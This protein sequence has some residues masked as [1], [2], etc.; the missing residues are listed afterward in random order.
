MIKPTKVNVSTYLNI[1]LDKLAPEL[2]RDGGGI[3]SEARK[4]T[5]FMGILH[6][7]GVIDRKI[8]IPRSKLESTIKRNGKRKLQE[9]ATI[10]PLGLWV[11]ISV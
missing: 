1:N 11:F 2:E 3:E 9:L 7:K 4:F 5:M 6:E 10:T 8:V